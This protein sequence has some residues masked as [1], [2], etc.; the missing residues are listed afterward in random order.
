MTPL[1]WRQEEAR[2]IKLSDL[3]KNGIPPEERH[4]TGKSRIVRTSE[5]EAPAQGDKERKRNEEIDY[6]ALDY[7]ENENPSDEET[8]ASNKKVPSLV[9]YPLP[10]SFNPMQ[11]HGKRT[12]N[13]W[14]RYYESGNAGE[15]DGFPKR[16]HEGDGDRQDESYGASRESGYPGNKREEC[17]S[18]NKR[19]DSNS[20]SKRGEFSSRT[21]RE[22]SNSRSKR[23]DSNSRNKR[24][25]SSSS[26][27]AE[28]AFRNEESYF[29][30]RD[31]SKGDKDG[32][33]GD[34][35]KDFMD[36]D[37]FSRENK[38][39]TSGGET[40]SKGVNASEDDAL[41]ENK[42]SEILAMAL[43]VQIKT[44]E[45]PPAPDLIPGYNKKRKEFGFGNEGMSGDYGG[46]KNFHEG[47]GGA[48]LNAQFGELNRFILG[49]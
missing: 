14:E 22:E 27:R 24:E 3:E 9:Q 13:S 11:K 23:G 31:D 42:K 20:R 16:S 44:G 6:N 33:S 21:E 37:G 25:K 46:V 10:G 17:N 38:G 47:R 41:P 35:S 48:H 29:K 30:S 1:H 28:S 45:D 5:N 39:G 36:K 32:F 18:R 15:R 2:V 43:G 4:K 40:A 34:F 49:V 8:Y 7:E 19:G 12:K 26:N